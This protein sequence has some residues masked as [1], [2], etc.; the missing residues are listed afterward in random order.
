MAKRNI[1]IFCAH[2]DDEVIGPGGT[3]L[4]Y[5]KKGI[6][7][8]V[9]IFS[10][11]EK[12]HVWYDEKKLITKRE[13]ES[14]NAGK[15]LQAKRI[16]NLK[17]ADGKLHKEIESPEVNEKVKKLILKYN[18]EKIFTHAIDDM[19]YPDHRAVHDCVVNAVKEL[20]EKK[21]YSVY[22]FNIWTINVRKRNAPRLV[23]DITEE[24]ERKTEALKCFKTQYLALFQ[25]RPLVYI[26][27]LLAGWKNG[28]KY[29]EEFH[30]II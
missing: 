15:I 4:N 24:F 22:T 19:L 25:L 14:N 27:A 12:S 29:A 20:R 5:A 3:I 18:P 30:K 28:T 6:N 16:I 10:G 11:G 9:V 13:Q 17:L 8:Y 21:K 2:P 26:K 1:L 23:V 7:T